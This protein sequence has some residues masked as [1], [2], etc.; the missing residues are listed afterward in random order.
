[1]LR[2]RRRR[3]DLMVAVLCLSASL[4]LGTGSQAA[5]QS[6]AEAT[7][8]T[9]LINRMANF[10]DTADAFTYT[11]SSTNVTVVADEPPST[12]FSTVRVAVRRPDRLW[13]DLQSDEVHNRFLYDG[14]TF[15]VQHLLENVYA[16]HDA[17][18][19]IRQL[20][21]LV[22]NELGIFIPLGAIWGG[23][24]Q[25]R[26]MEGVDDITYLDFQDVDGVACHHI[27]AR[28]S[29]LD[30]EVWIEDGVRLVPRKVS[31]R[32]VDGDISTTFSAVLSQWDFAPHLPDSVFSQPPPPNAQRIELLASGSN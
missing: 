19:S 3:R 17:P 6:E 1:M 9:E 29:D 7:F 25:A 2:L 4:T 13:V 14:A 5:A 12:M 10:L 18:G 26:V 31:I 22:E 20:L 30:W 23:D 8:A 28:Q 21:D 11:S 15:Q 27:H 32:F 24:S 16:T